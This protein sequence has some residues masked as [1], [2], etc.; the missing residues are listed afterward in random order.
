VAK[1]YVLFDLDARQAYSY[2]H[3][4]H[5]KEYR[6]SLKD[7]ESFVETLT[8]KIIEADDTIPEL[9]SKDVIFRIYRDIRF[10]ND[11]TPYK[12]VT[13]LFGLSP[14]FWC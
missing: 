1:E 14:A 6:R 12:V 5:D 3:P 11:P 8:Q 2:H 4:A 10:S 7:W 13:F 9:P